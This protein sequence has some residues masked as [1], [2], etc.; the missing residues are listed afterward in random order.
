MLSLFLGKSFLLSYL[1][2]THST[3]STYNWVLLVGKL[4][5][6]SSQR[7]QSKAVFRGFDI[8]SRKSLDPEKGESCFRS[9]RAKG[10]FFVKYLMMK[11]SASSV[12]NPTI[13]H[14]V[15][16]SRLIFTSA[17]CLDVKTMRHLDNSLLSASFKYMGSLLGSASSKP[18]S[19]NKTLDWFSRMNLKKFSLDSLSTSS[20]RICSSIASQM[21]VSISWH[22]SSSSNSI[23]GKDS[24]HSSCLFAQSYASFW[25]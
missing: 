14:R 9:L 17:S 3:I 10:L 25:Q 15:S 11:V 23:S 12:V 24:S 18:S 13:S 22:L 2:R 4:P 20:G 21:L 1:L 19:T 16:Q 5:C 6:K 7:T 8:I